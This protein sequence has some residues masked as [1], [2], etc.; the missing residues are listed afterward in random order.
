MI[1]PT[2]ASILAHDF[3]PKPFDGAFLAA[4]LG[5]T[6][7][8]PCHQLALI[9]E[10]CGPLAT[11][12]LLQKTV[13]VEASG[14]SWMPEY[15]R[16]RTPGGTF[17]WLHRQW[18][19]AVPQGGRRHAHPKRAS[20]RPQLADTMPPLPATYDKGECS[21]KMTLVGTPGTVTDHATYVLF[22]VSGKLPPSLPKGLPTPAEPPLDWVVLVGKKQWTKAAASLAS[23]PQTKLILEGYPC[24]QGATHVLLV[25]QCTTTALQRAKQAPQGG[26]A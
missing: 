22:P 8:D 15:E 6:A 1:E 26:P 20:V 16:R 17:F 24:L 10:T 14:G 18:Y 5:E 25:T 4:A 23:D 21:V 12:R 13:E 2:P 7:P 19:P 9:R 11:W 3:P